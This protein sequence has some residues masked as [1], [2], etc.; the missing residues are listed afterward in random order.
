MKKVYLALAL[1]GAVVPY[2]Q[3]LPWLRLNSLNL[4]LFV[5]QLFAN[6]IS[7]FFALD[8]LLTAV[9]LVGFFRRSG[10]HHR[11]HHL[12]IPIIGTLLIGPSFGLPI[13]LNLYEIATQTEAGAS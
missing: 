5:Q 6:K 4:H 12:W 8:L 11:V 10:A 13:F 7:S 9:V 3:F 2:S 1:L